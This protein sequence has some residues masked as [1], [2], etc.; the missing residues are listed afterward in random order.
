VYR[1]DA[2]A[3]GVDKVLKTLENATEKFII[4]QTLGKSLCSMKKNNMKIM[5]LYQNQNDHEKGRRKLSCSS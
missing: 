3:A 4:F 5:N 1:Y 2:L